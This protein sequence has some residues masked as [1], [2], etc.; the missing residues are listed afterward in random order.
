A[1]LAGVVGQ[2]AVENN[3]F[4]IVTQGVEKVV[5][6]NK[7]ENE[8]K[9]KISANCKG[10][11][12]IIPVPEKTVSDN[13][14][15]LLNDLTLR[16]FAAVVDL[17]YDPVTGEQITPKE[18]QMAKASALALG[19]SKSLSGVTKLSD[20]VII[21]IEKKYSKDIAQKIEN[22]FY[23]DDDL[24]S[25]TKVREEGLKNAENIS[26]ANNPKNI[27]KG[28]VN[29]PRNVQEQIVWDDVMKNPASGRELRN[30][31]GD[32]R[33]PQDAGFVKMERIVRTVEGKNIT[34]H[35]QYNYVTKKTY[36]MKVV[37]K[38][39]NEQ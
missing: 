36:D 11:S 10:Q 8:L 30:L 13:I 31:N 7:K 12:C 16:Q 35:Y 9:V 14:V 37:N 39:L 17:Q 23:R 27:A 6:K 4:S 33:F 38:P 5:V 24:I 21:A 19:F 1:Q 28:Q 15:N 26:T 3:E 32:S 18:R 29:Q 25:R 22:N 20:E 2:N 34:I